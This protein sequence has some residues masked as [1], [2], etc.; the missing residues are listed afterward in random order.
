[1]WSYSRGAIGVPATVRLDVGSSQCST[2]GDIGLL[3][4]YVPR[5]CLPEGRFVGGYRAAERRAGI[6]FHE[7]PRQLCPGL[8]VADM[9]EL[10][11]LVLSQV[12]AAMLSRCCMCCVGC[13]FPIDGDVA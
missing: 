8:G 1:M 3:A 9:A 13:V 7:Y 6:T 12:K 2:V 10:R 4:T 5:F 11:G